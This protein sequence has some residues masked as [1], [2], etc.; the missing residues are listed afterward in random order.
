LLVFFPG[1]LKLSRI[2]RSMKLSIGDSSAGDQY[3]ASTPSRV[4]Y[5]NETTEVWDISQLLSS[6][7]LTDTA[8]SNFPKL[9]FNQTAHKKFHESLPSEQDGQGAY[10]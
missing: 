6:K 2:Q 8:Q 4:L 7:P 3:E 1:F 5:V 10:N 9:P